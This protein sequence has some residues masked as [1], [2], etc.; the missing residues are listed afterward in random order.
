M[1]DASNDKMKSFVL[2]ILA[3]TLPLVVQAKLIV[4]VEPAKTTGQ[5]TVI[6]LNLKNTFAQKIDSARAQ[7]FLSND[8]GKVV[9]QA[10]QWVIGGTKEKS[11]LAPEAS[12]TFNFVVTTDKPFTKS[13]V[14]F[15]KIVLD[16]GKAA[17]PKEVDISD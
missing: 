3:L 2:I 4:K 14:I 5:K 7:L 15:T 10:T 17:D 6:K 8:E 11:A 13:K 12:T 1:P 9:G 16:G